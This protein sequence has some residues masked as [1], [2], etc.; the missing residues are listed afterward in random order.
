MRMP[1]RASRERKRPAGDARGGPLAGASAER[2]Y[3]FLSSL[4]RFLLV[5]ALVAALRF[6]GFGFAVGAPAP[7]P[8]R[9]RF[10]RRRCGFLGPRRRAFG[11]T[12]VATTG[13][14][15]PRVTTRHARRQLQRRHVDR[16]ADVELATG[17]PR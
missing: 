3:F 4:P 11:T 16:M 6:G 12:A 15:L 14:V 10:G 5:A 9:R 1:H 13:S 8:R 7:Q 2:A 17:R